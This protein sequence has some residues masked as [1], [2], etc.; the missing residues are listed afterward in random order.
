MFTQYLECTT[1]GG[2]IRLHRFCWRQE[3]RCAGQS[4]Y[5]AS[6]LRKIAR[7]DETAT[8]GVIHQVVAYFLSNPIDHIDPMLFICAFDALQR[9]GDDA[10]FG[11][12]S[13]NPVWRSA[14]ANL[15]DPRSADVLRRIRAPEPQLQQAAAA[16]A[17]SPFTRAARHALD[18]HLDV[19][20]NSPQRL[21]WLRDLWR[22]AITRN[23]TD[24]ARLAR[25]AGVEIPTIA[26]RGSRKPQHAELPQSFVRAHRTLSGIHGSSKAKKAAYAVLAWLC[27]HPTGGY[28]HFFGHAVPPRLLDARDPRWVRALGRELRVLLSKGGKRDADLVQL[29]GA[30][31]SFRSTEA[32]H[33]IRGALFANIEKLTARPAARLFVALVAMADTESV[34]D[35]VA[36]VKTHPRRHA[37][38][39][40]VLEYLNACACAQD[41]AEI[42]PAITQ[43]G[44]GWLIEDARLRESRP[45]HAPKA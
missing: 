17:R 41:I 30:L 14:L 33:Q 4:H 34:D 2:T 26:R 44:D 8:I 39:G 45:R 16:L 42:L 37:A 11:W 22:L 23:T 36:F 31:L 1:G 24:P 12:I 19:D 29:V 43:V 40:A 32:R 25:L 27:G 35:A 13:T 20:G 10:V 15:P 21:S 6:V 3:L 18:E 9:L 5:T 38:I 28:A 7:L